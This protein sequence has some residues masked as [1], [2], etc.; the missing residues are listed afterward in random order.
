[1]RG[2]LR[3]YL[4]A[5]PGV[6]KTFAML[7]EGHRRAERGT[8]VV[9]GIVETHGRPLT[10]AKVAGLEQ[11]PRRRVAYRDQL[12]EE[13]D[14]AAI[15]RRRPAVV[16]VDELAHTNIP[17][18]EHEKRWED[19]EDLLAAGIDVVSTINLQH[20][21]SV[22]D[23]VEAITGTA[24][25]E[26]VPDSFVRHAQQVQLVDITPEALRRRMAHGNIY[27]A[28]RVDAALSNFFRQGNL[29]ALRELALLWLADRVDDELQAYR[30]RHQ[31]SNAWET[32]ERLV[33]SITGG[34]SAERLIRRAARMAARAR[35]EL[36][37]VHVRPDDGLKRPSDETLN[38]SVELLEELDGRYIEVVDSDVAAALVSVAR[39]ENATQLVIGADPKSRVATFLR[40]S[41]V[42]R[43]V[44]L[45]RG[46]LDVHVISS[47]GAE[48]GGATPRQRHVVRAVSPRRFWGSLLLAGLAIPLLTLSLIHSGVA[49]LALA[50]SS[51]LLVVIAVAAIGGLIPGL[52]GA[53]ASFLVTNWEFTPPIHT[54]TIAHL[55][56][57]VALVSYLTA[58][59]VVAG[60]VDVAARRSWAAARA[61][62][63]ALGLARIARHVVST[64]H[65]LS[66]MLTEIVDL[67]DLRGAE[68]R[69]RPSNAPW[70]SAGTVGD[71]PT[72]LRLGEDYELCVDG[73][74]LSGSRRDLLVAISAQVVAALDRRRLEDEAAQ[75]RTLAD[76]ERLRT[77]LLAAVSHDLRTPLASI[78][79]AATTLLD[80]RRRISDR[81][82]DSLLS[83]IDAQA[84]HL[85]RLVGDL[86]DVARVSEGTVELHLRDVDVNDVV[87]RAIETTTQ[88][89]RSGEE[90]IHFVPTSPLT[91]TSDATIIER[92]LVNL[93]SNALTHAAPSPVV[94][95]IGRGTDWVSVRVIDHGPGVPDAQRAALFE[96]FSTL[97]D[98]KDQG[99]VGLGLALARGF[100]EALGGELVLDDTPGVGCTLV[101]T[102]P[103]R[104][105]D[106]T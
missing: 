10:A 87:R 90:R 84:D 50:L 35:A 78:K 3:I 97:G 68:L 96:P 83:D 15:L 51:Y 66:D 80:A 70:V 65:A 11:I 44:A 58:A 33:V 75:R 42:A 64:D 24:Q 98:V 54:F 53:L 2:Q 77:G 102:L 40:G 46:D 88:E 95:D 32:R 7:D 73:N 94:V 81:D 20:L 12:F 49:S 59:A 14:L 6:G 19:V 52:M 106:A 63:D 1:M 4:G 67:F 104:P 69:R 30:E 89:R 9:I 85:N 103:P 76:A 18:T 57:V 47:D 71:S 100:A 60:F 31:I 41:I 25:R 62:R 91:I 26:T 105:V 16:L 5:A 101:L 72:T 8:D 34:E 45:A 99:G 56:D 92:I 39:A 79:T 82:V 36:V 21:E 23:V 61:E 37:G 17:G 38:H 48:R 55:R 22:N 43:C 13:M 74:Q 29:A 93:L 86:L 27:A 28:D